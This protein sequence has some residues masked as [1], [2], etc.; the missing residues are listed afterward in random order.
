MPSPSA[1]ASSR[2]ASSSSPACALAVA[3][4][5]RM[6]TFPAQGVAAARL[7]STTRSASAA[8]DRTSSQRPVTLASRICQARRVQAVMG[9]QPGRGLGGLCAGPR[10]RAEVA[11]L[12]VHEDGST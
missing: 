5:S 11:G 4:F 12:Q 2:R 6:E 8:P 10:R 1:L 9:G 3:Q 7:A